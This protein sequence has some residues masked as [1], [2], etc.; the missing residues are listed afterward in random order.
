M[1]DLKELSTPFAANDLEWFVGM[2]TKDKTKGLAMPYITNRAVQNRLDEVCGV[3]GWKNEYKALKDSD[4]FDKDGTIKGKKFSYL[5]GISVWSEQRK[6]WITKWDGAEETDIES[7]KGG[8]SAAMKRAATQLGIGRY[9]YYLDN[10]WVDIEQKGNSYV[11]KANQEFVLPPWAL[12]GGKG[13]P[14]AGES[15]RVTVKI[16]GGNNQQGTQQDN[17]GQQGNQ[18]GTQGQGNQKPYKLSDAQVNR[19]L[20]KATAAGMGMDD[21]NLWISKKYGAED[22]KDLNR[23]QYDALCEALDNAKK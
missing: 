21:I 7:L 5:C 19:A 17:Q 18:Q 9:L 1:G 15:T 10:P 8:L 12:P 11:I 14:V 6:E 23:Q 2:T 4:I 20:K 13:Y 22:I 3:D 16:K